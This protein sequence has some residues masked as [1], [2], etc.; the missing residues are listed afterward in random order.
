MTLAE[1][2][3]KLAAGETSATQLVG[4]A[5]ARINDPNGEGARTFVRTFE[6]EARAAAA[7]WDVM[8]AAGVPVP[9]LAGI[10]ISVKDLFDVAGT[11][12]TA[13][14]RAL[15][16]A[17][18]AAHDAPAVARLR[19]A[20]AAIVGAT[21]MTE[22]AMGGIGIN[23]HYGTPRNPY[24]RASGRIPG[25]SSSGAV[26]SITDGMAIA[27][28]GSDTAG[29]VRMPAALC[30]LVGFKP[31]ARRI[32]LA[33]S[34][35]L[36]PTLDSVGPLAWTVEDCALLDAILAGEPAQ[37]PAAIP[38]A[39]LRFAVPQTLVLEELDP[40]VEAAFARARAALARAGAH[41]VDIP[42]AELDEVRALNSSK[43][44]F[45][46]VEGYAWHRRLL[47]TKRD[48]YDPNIAPLFENG[49]TIAAA[50]Y[51]DLKAAREELV[52]RTRAVT[53][54]YDAVLM[55]TVAIIAPKIADLER[56]PAAHGSTNVRLIRNPGIA[57]L[58][59]RCA[60]TLP[61]H[62]R[63]DAPVG[64]TLMGET[65]TDKRLLGIALAAESVVSPKRSG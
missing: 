42:F 33:G 55:P 63:G 4:A 51:L 3:R 27:A 40:A 61:I 38:L 45:S 5:F 59:D 8:R 62:K 28:I 13:G 20:G 17:A 21:N 58:L 22:F 19:A 10:P 48:L 30:G 46:M 50:D 53:S 26:V 18:P 14:S 49:K 29:S 47:E 54:G 6:A 41:I 57:N 44:R 32:P 12:T 25:G 31:T 16:E 56:D 24:D 36:A 9:L 7:G 60:I 15:A 37:V 52:E 35:P 64:L 1:A 43:V 2:V 39:G 65:M 23:P 34:V 11:V